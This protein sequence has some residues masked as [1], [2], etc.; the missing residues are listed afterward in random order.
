MVS[1]FPDC[2]VS[3]PLANDFSRVPSLY[4]SA[5]VSVP[6]AAPPMV[7]E[8][9]VNETSD[10]SS[11]FAAGFTARSATAAGVSVV[12]YCSTLMSCISNECMRASLSRW[13][14]R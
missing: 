12:V 2:R 6:T 4:T 5:V 14:P 7:F 1:F 13:K 8:G 10:F 11:P 9:S 3:S